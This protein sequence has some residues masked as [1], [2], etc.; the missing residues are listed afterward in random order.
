M[1]SNDYRLVN[2]NGKCFKPTKKYMRVGADGYLYQA[3]CVNLP[4]IKWEKCE[5]ITEK[6]DGNK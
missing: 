3:G 1:G 5:E 2:I 6:C 4:G